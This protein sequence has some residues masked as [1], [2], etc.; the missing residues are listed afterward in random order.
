MT[1]LER[2][3]AALEAIGTK[4]QVHPG[5]LDF[6]HA[7][8]LRSMR[9]GRS[10]SGSA[11]FDGGGHFAVLYGY[12]E[13]KHGDRQVLVSDPLFPDSIVD[14]DEFVSAY[15]SAGHWTGTILLQG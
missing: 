14:Y 3:E 5:R 9:A 13:S 15:Q 11:W 7:E 10:V 2:L 4:V 1:R 6:K 12:R 8:T